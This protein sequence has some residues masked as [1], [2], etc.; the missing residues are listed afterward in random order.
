MPSISGLKSFVNSV[1]EMVV[2]DDFFQVRTDLN[3]HESCDTSGL[4]RAMISLYGKDLVESVCNSFATQHPDEKGDRNFA[5]NFHMAGRLSRNIALELLARAAHQTTLTHVQD[6]ASK[7]NKLLETAFQELMDPLAVIC[8]LPNLHLIDELRATGR[9]LDSQTMGFAIHYYEMN[10]CSKNLSVE[11]LCQPFVV[12]ESL[13]RAIAYAKT[14]CDLID[15]QIP[16]YIQG[17]PNLTNYKISGSINKN[18]LNVYLLCPIFSNPN[19]PNILAFR[20]TKD[21]RS[22]WRDMDLKGVGYTEFH[23]Q[24][25]DL[26]QLVGHSFKTNPTDSLWIVGHSLGAVDAQRMIIETVSHISEMPSLRHLQLYAYCSPKLDQPSCDNWKSVF[27]QSSQ[28]LKIDLFYASHIDDF[29]S[30][31]GNN[32]LT[33]PTKDIATKIQAQAHYLRMHDELGHESSYKEAHCHPF[34]MSGAVNPNF[35]FFYFNELNP[36]DISHL[37]SLENTCHQALLDLLHRQNQLLDEVSG[38]QLM[39]DTL[40]QEIQKLKHSPQSEEILRELTKLMNERQM[41]IQLHQELEQ[42]NKELAEL[43]KGYREAFAHFSNQIKQLNQNS[44]QFDAI[45]GTN[46]SA[47][48]KI[49]QDTISGMLSGIKRLFSK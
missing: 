27:S 23:D 26:L 6:Y 13:A 46:R 20:G 19:H 25:Q 16:I 32:L 9:K 38:A 39:I 18:G 7:K 42:K 12:P 1:N 8:D 31:Y 17:Q 24:K 36:S 5:H 4:L 29:I 34:F 45:R 14:D 3:R 2:D 28:S 41:Q 48:G 33:V 30:Y 10:C 44:P 37:E 47:S 15:K 35:R 21:L 49:T 22:G 11:G 43:K 40:E